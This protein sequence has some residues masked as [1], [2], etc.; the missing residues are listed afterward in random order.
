MNKQSPDLHSQRLHWL[1]RP[2]LLLLL[3]ILFWS[4]NLVLG[5]AVRT[6]IPPIG[7]AFWRWLVGSLLVLPLARS[8]L[9]PDLP[10][11]LRHWKI[12]TLFAVLGVT[13][14]NTLVYTGLR[15]T[16]AIN[17]ALLQTITPLVIVLFSY[18][19]FREAISTVQIIGILISLAGVLIITMRG[20]WQTLSQLS[21]NHGDIWIFIAV[22]GYALYVTLQRLR[23]VIHPL[24]F[25]AV[26]FV[27]GT[28]MIVPFYIWEHINGAIVQWN[29][30]TIFSVLYVAIFP[31][32]LAY[33]CYDRGVLLLG[34]N[35]AGQFLNLIPLCSSLM[36]ILLLGETFQVF[37]GIGMVLILGGIWLVTQHQF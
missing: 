14:F 10:Q 36:A 11:I 37:H 2:Y 15:S 23:P 20:E 5:R 24:S 33:F 21:L 32:I 16:T 31:S 27:L 1:D 19:L 25:M 9:K 7:L 18:L 3:A 34:A 6:E 30:V 26:T 4:G 29:Q 35:R 22:I 17:G 8:H 28:G 12:M 13:M